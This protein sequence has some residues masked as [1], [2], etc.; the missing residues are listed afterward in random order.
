MVDMNHLFERFVTE[1]LRRALR[2][3][4]DVKDQ[5]SDKLDKEG[6]LAIRPDLVFGSQGSA[7][8]VADV[9]YKLTD[10]AAGGHSA[11][12]YQPL[13]YTTAL[14]LP[15]GMLI[16]CLDT[17]R[18]DSDAGNGSPPRSNPAGPGGPTP[19]G[20]TADAGKAVVSTVRVRHTGKVLHTYALDLSGTPD[21]VG[22]DMSA[23]AGWI[24]NHAAAATGQDRADNRGR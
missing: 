23:L 15:E 7:K 20:T 22:R 6:T 16:Y 12:Y 17:D 3:R 13:A 24:A 2:G 19:P 5:Y 1:R 8:F 10:E 18:P 21:E 14:D 11:D 9:K 4:L